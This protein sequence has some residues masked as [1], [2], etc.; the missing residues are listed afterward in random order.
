MRLLALTE[1]QDRSVKYLVEETIPD[2]QRREDELSTDTG[3]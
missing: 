2:D 3:S 1:K